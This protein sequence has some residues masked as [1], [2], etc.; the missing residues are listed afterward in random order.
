MTQPASYGA[1]LGEEKEVVMIDTTVALFVFL[2][3]VMAVIAMYWDRVVFAATAWWN[4]MDTEQQRQFIAVMV[5]HLV[6]AAEIS[7]PEPGNGPTRKS[8]VMENLRQRYAW[9]SDSVLS[10]MVEAGV[11][12]MKAR[13][14]RGAGNG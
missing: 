7:L 12:R 9:L 5:D 6:T 8:V 4:D 11:R 14:G 13:Q 10:A 1:G 2:L 3:I